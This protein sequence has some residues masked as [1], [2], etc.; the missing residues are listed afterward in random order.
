M[1]YSRTYGTDVAS[2]PPIHGVI[3][4]NAQLIEVI[5]F[6]SVHLSTLARRSGQPQNDGNRNKNTKRNKMRSAIAITFPLV[7][8][9]TLLVDVIGLLFTTV[10]LYCCCFTTLYFC[11]HEWGKLA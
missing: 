3:D 7:S 9:M 6:R 5:I 2:D 10:A 11:L 4:Q 1:S 8:D